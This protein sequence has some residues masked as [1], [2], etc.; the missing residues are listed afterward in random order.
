M[1][2][3]MSRLNS[4][5]QAPGTGSEKRNSDI[6]IVNHQGKKKI[7]ELVVSCHIR[8]GRQTVLRHKRKGCAEAQSQLWPRVVYMTSF[9]HHRVNVCGKRCSFG[10]SETHIHFSSQSIRKSSLLEDWNTQETPNALVLRRSSSCQRTLPASDRH[11]LI[12]YVNVGSRTK[13][14]TVTADLHLRKIM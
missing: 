4:R 14:A 13:T 10:L 1:F 3:S 9:T 11:G 7:R 2:G 6:V 12:I 5:L 8:N